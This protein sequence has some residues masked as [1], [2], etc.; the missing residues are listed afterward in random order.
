[1][2][3]LELTDEYVER[4]RGDPFQFF[5]LPKSKVDVIIT[6]S[7]RTKTF[8]RFVKQEYPNSP[9]RSVS[10]TFPDPTPVK[11]LAEFLS[12]LL[13]SKRYRSVDLLMKFF[14]I[15]S[16]CFDVPNAIFLQLLPSLMN[17]FSYACFK[18]NVSSS[19]T[20]HC[21]LWFSGEF[22]NFLNILLNTDDD[23]FRQIHNNEFCPKFD[24][25]DIVHEVWDIVCGEKEGT[26][27]EISKEIPTDIFSREPISPKVST[28][29]NRL[30]IML[31]KISEN[32][33]VKK[34]ERFEDLF[35]PS[36][37]SVY[38]V[39]YEYKELDE[40]GNDNF[41]NRAKYTYVKHHVFSRIPI[42]SWNVKR[43]KC[44]SRLFKSQVHTVL[45]MQ[46][47]RHSQFTIHKNLLKNLFDYMYFNYMMEI[48]DKIVEMQ[49]LME[50]LL[51]LWTRDSD[52]S[53]IEKLDNIF[54]DEEFGLAY[55]MAFETIVDFTKHKMGLLE[56]KEY[57]KYRDNL[58]YRMPM[59][60][61]LESVIDRIKHKFVEEHS[62]SDSVDHINKIKQK[63]DAAEYICQKCKER[64]IS[65]VDVRY[66]R[67]NLDFIV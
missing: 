26:S 57:K 63:I 14:R 2:E 6:K 19:S 23:L 59:W 21:N 7:F 3:D 24:V 34:I 66:G 55:G 65:L 39:F 13:R 60:S 48:K 1:M 9:F 58:Y 33:E 50:P 62:L 10:Y 20:N 45:G 16:V 17:Y 64:N 30:S 35:H 4:L 32:P 42:P 47:F 31:R 53:H 22:H 67:V 40:E 41:L 56:E 29:F 12:K 44:C 18:G 49:I 37:M 15:E 54:I 46:R 51:S 52:G 27:E 25:F 38:S 43:H 36:F 8:Q 5:K 28:L 11:F 61:P